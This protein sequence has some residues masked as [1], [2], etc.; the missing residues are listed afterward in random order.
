MTK[1]LKIAFVKARWHAPIVDQTQIGF[2]E[3]MQ[4]AE[5]RCDVKEIH[6]PG[7]LE[8]P[9]VA[10]KLAETG[11]YDG[12]VCAALVVNGGIYRH[13]FVAQAVVDGLVRAG[14]DTGVPVYSVSLTPHEFQETPDHIEFYTK[15]FVKKGAEAARAVLAMDAIEY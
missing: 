9:L 5:R 7:A 11:K 14:M 10:K 1:P 6:V 15:H 4:K 2:E 8:M 13:E 3:E 12:I